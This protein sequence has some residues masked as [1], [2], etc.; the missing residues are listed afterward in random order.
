MLEA[1][2]ALGSVYRRLG[3][4][5]AASEQFRLARAGSSAAQ[6][7]RRLTYLQGEVLRNPA[8]PMVHFQ[9]GCLEEELKDVAG[10]R[11]EFEAAAALDPHMPDPHAHLAE[12]D[13][14]QGRSREAEQHRVLAKRLSSEMGY[15][16]RMSS[17][18]FAAADHEPL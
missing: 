5:A 10:A 1:R 13:E 7:D 17:S 12:L 9:L 4:E 6:R 2:H 16:S 18:L 8:N 11:R 14:R 15:L 3:K